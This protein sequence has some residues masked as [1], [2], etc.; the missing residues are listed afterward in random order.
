MELLYFAWQVDAR[1][2]A[3][4][5]NIMLHPVFFAIGTVQIEENI[6]EELY[7]WAYV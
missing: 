6:M 5:H 3:L 2:P 1:E 7:I 4:S